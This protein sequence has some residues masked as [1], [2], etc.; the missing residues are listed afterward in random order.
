MLTYVLALEQWEQPWLLLPVTPN[1]VEVAESW[2]GDVLEPHVSYMS[3]GSISFAPVPSNVQGRDGWTA[4]L[5]GA[6]FIQQTPPA[7]H[8]HRQWLLLREVI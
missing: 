2:L 6:G 8:K 1:T 4:R 5:W 7:I 3:W